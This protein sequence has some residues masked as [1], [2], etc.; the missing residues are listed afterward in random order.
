LGKKR[1]EERSLV[2]KG[3]S[4]SFLVW[5]MRKLTDHKFLFIM[6]KGPVHILKVT[7]H[8]AEWNKQQGQILSLLL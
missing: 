8:N 3:T 2:D 1:T 6:N 5:K 7:P 4:Y